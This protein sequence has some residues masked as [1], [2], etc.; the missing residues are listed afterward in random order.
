MRRCNCM[1]GCHGCAQVDGHLPTPG[2]V[3]CPTP[4]APWLQSGA[5]SS[6]TVQGAVQG[7]ELTAQG[8]VLAVR[9]IQ[10]T[11]GKCL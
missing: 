5:R 8:S 3:E 10:L 7:A 2:R 9:R 6:C 11:I 4:G 1:D